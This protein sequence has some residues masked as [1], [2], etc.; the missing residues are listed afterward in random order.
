[1]K[2]LI[3]STILCLSNVVN[4]EFLLG[5]ENIP[6]EF[7]QKIKNARIG[8]I[9]NQTGKD[10]CGSNNISV[11]ERK[12]LSLKKIFTPEHG[13][14]GN[15]P[16]GCDVVSVNN[17]ESSIPIIS[18]YRHGKGTGIGKTEADEID[19]FMFDIQDS[20]MRHYT[21]ISTLLQTMEAAA[22][23]DKNYVVLDRPNPL[24]NRMEGPLVDVTQQSFI[25]IAPIPLRHGLTI[26]ELAWYFNKS[27]LKKPAKL[28]VIRMHDYN[29]SMGLTQMKM[30]FPALSPNIKHIQSCYGYSLLGLLGEVR[31]LDV[32][33]GTDKAFQ[34]I[35]LPETLS[36]EDKKWNELQH[37]L[38]QHGISS[39]LYQRYNDA[40]KQNFKGLEIHITDINNSKSFDALLS[41]LQFFQKNGT[42]LSFSKDFD[43]AI[44]TKKIRTFIKGSTN[45]KELT[46]SINS[47]LKDFLEKVQPALLYKPIPQC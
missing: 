4:A 34:V 25:S 17:V 12:G 15:V 37:I 18:L 8:L 27:I 36:Y 35:L 19:V 32:G 14:E 39:S 22:L 16:A 21:Y 10:Q 5:L 2:L 38:K 24:G 1:M 29:R 11:L 6:Q 13:F 28:H 33:I 40:K 44:G 20:G 26:G 46:H 45:Y 7:I 43:T 23:Y 30:P 31:P 3:W 9:T 42:E 47:N 41:I